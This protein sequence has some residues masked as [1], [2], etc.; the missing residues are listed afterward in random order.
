VL[1]HENDIIDHAHYGKDEFNGVNLDV[2]AVGGFEGHLQEREE[3][4]GEVQQDV[5]D[6]PTHSG[7]TFVIPIHLRQIFE[8]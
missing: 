5:S 4:A 7:F 8:E 3:A 2:L 6:T 1:N